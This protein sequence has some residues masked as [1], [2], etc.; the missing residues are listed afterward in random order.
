MRIDK[1]KEVIKQTF[2]EDVVYKIDFWDI[3]NLNAYANY[4]LKMKC[5]N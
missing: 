5:T 1:N 2:V 3:L 4:K